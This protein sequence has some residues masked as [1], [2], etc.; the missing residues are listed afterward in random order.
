MARL[1]CLLEAEHGTEVGRFD[2]HVPA[3]LQ[4]QVQF[5]ALDHLHP[6]ERNL[7][8]GSISTPV[9]CIL[10]TLMAAVNPRLPLLL[11]EVNK[12]PE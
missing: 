10:V 11:L 1:P 3:E 6:D 4:P 5:A 7:P 12:V 2:T 8:P 9:P